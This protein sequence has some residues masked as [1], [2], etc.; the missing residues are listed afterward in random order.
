MHFLLKK[1]FLKSKAN[2]FSINLVHSKKK[3]TEA[4][5]EP[6]QI[7]KM[8]HFVKIVND[9]KALAI[10]AK[11]SILDVWQDS[12]YASDQWPIF[13][14]YI[15]PWI[16]A[17][18]YFPETFSWLNPLSQPY[19]MVKHTQT[20]RRMLPTNCLSVFEHFLGLS[21]KRLRISCLRNIWKNI[22]FLI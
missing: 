21:L 9:K 11:H 1:L 19:K 3:S 6:C 10:F 14:S 12:E 2:A 16:F 22:I 5:S 17:I 13:K 7:F 8:D 20:I 18:K 15:E 4:Y